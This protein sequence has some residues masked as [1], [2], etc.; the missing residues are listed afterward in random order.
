MVNLIIKKEK[1]LK[2]ILKPNQKLFFQEKMIAQ[3]NMLYFFLKNNTTKIQV[4][5]WN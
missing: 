3:M 2:K 5:R 1:H 4:I